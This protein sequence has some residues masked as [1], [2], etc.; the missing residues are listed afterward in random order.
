MIK[1][2]FILVFTL[3]LNILLVGCDNNKASS[4]V[5][6]QKTHEDPITIGFEESSRD[7]LYVNDFKYSPRLK[8]RIK[9]NSGKK[10]DS[11]TVRLVWIKDGTTQLC[12]ASNSFFNI[13]PNLL[14]ELLEVRSSNSIEASDPREIAS[15]AW[16]GDY[17]GAAKM[18]VDKEGNQK[19]L[20]D[21]LN[22]RIY[23]SINSGQEILLSDTPFEGKITST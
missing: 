19:I 11:V 1:H 22:I 12:S 3:L 23:Y 15:K 20:N 9:N 16:K 8:F 5:K 10:I 6:V 13:E 7:W 21:N 2:F 17:T 14:T 18:M 4:E